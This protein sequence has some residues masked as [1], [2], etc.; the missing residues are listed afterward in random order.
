MNILDSYN[1]LMSKNVVPYTSIRTHIP[2]PTD[3]DYKR[4]YIARYFTQIANDTNSIIYEIN[5]TTFSRLQT[6]P[7]YV[8]VSLKWRITGP[9]E[10]TYREDGQLLDM[11]VAESN[12]KAILLHYDKIPNLKLYLP[13]LLQ[14]YK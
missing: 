3:S 8:V 13:N 6:N 1:K 4:G 10:T 11:S 9:K 5:S 2:D 7:M 12:R 14:F